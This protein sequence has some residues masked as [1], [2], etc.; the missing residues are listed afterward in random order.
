MSSP[1]NLSQNQAHDSDP[2][3]RAIA[4]GNEQCPDGKALAQLGRLIRGQQPLATDLRARV[5]THMAIAEGQLASDDGERVDHLYEQG[6]A[7]PELGRLR[8]LFAGI[9][10][11]PVDLRARVRRQLLASQRLAPV[12]VEAPVSSRAQAVQ[13]HVRQRRMRVITTVVVGHLAAVL[14]VAVFFANRSPAPV[15]DNS[16]WTNAM[17]P[18]PR[19][20]ERGPQSWT[21]IPGSGFDLFAL[22]RSPELRAAAR[23]RFNS[24]RSAGA[25]ACGLRWL[26]AQQGS[27]GRFATAQNA[28]AD[29]ATRDAAVCRHALATLALLGEGGGTTSIDRERMQAAQ[30]ALAALN[31]ASLLVDADSTC[32]TRSLVTLARVEGALLGA[33]PH[34]VADLALRDLA[35][36][37][38]A[39]GLDGFGLLAVETAQQGGLSVPAALLE[40]SRQTLVAPTDA[41]EPD[42]ARLGLIT[43]ARATLGYRDNPATTALSDALAGRA[44]TMTSPA[45]PQ[46]WL[47]ATLA[48]REMGGPAWDTWIAGLQSRV[49][50]SFVDA[51]PGMAYVGTDAQSD[52]VGAT[53]TAVLELQVAYR[54][55]PLSR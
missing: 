41:N 4:N 25:V 51:G 52:T 8:D 50:P 37:L 53:A 10:P 15:N 35:E 44:P 34:A 12:T 21:Q 36:H 13:V 48:L 28:T 14:V 23:T 29:A 49:L 19:V 31:Q 30:Q 40:R 18:V 42:L 54:Y 45:E 9:A 39:T 17:P 47:F 11:Q 5:E 43:F 33:C 7:D 27:D 6:G 46:A 32:Q 22:R 2:L 16:T 24:E 20:L 1:H 55:L 38:P 3:L 26:L